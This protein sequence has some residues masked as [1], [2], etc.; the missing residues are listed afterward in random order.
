MAYP[1]CTYIYIYI[2]RLHHLSIFVD[3]ISTN[4]LRQLLD[5]NPMV[6]IIGSTVT[7]K[8]S[9]IETIKPEEITYIYR[10]RHLQR[11]IDS[12]STNVRHQSLDFN[13]SVFIIASTITE[14]FS[15]RETINPKRLLIINLCLCWISL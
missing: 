11:F 12:I 5:F 15:Y 8:F 7:K 13:S 10:P 9:Y 14:K 2:Y 1:R 4:D 6:F 3:S